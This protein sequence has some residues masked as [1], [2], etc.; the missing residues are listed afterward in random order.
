MAWTY[1]PLTGKQIIRL[2]VFNEIREKMNEVGYAVRYYYDF[3]YEYYNAHYTNLPPALLTDKYICTKALADEFESLYKME[4]PDEWNT[5]HVQWFFSSTFYSLTFAEFL[6]LVI[7]QPAFTA[8]KS[9]MDIGTLINELYL[10]LDYFANNV[11]CPNACAGTASGQYGWHEDFWETSWSAARMAATADA[12]EGFNSLQEVYYHEP[13]EADTP[14]GVWLTLGAA[15]NYLDEFGYYAPNVVAQETSEDGN[16][17]VWGWW[18][19]YLFNMV[20]WPDAHKHASCTYKMMF[21]NQATSSAGQIPTT[22]YLN[23]TSLGVIGSGHVPQG[24]V[25]ID[26]NQSLIDFTLPESPYDE[27]NIMTCDENITAFIPPDIPSASGNWSEGVNYIGGTTVYHEEQ[28]Y[29]CI[30]DHLSS[31]SNE[32][33]HAGSESYW[34]ITGN[35]GWERPEEGSISSYI[36]ATLYPQSLMVKPYISWT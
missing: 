7:G 11:W 30:Q 9:I 24:R 3:Y 16:Q 5:D 34:E 8:P 15:T 35:Y 26:I 1:L 2:E 32:P 18:T 29:N 27:K 33:G 17:A 36:W 12:Q 10:A 4:T 23:G 14:P 6:T 20:Y 31:Y 22:F 28:Y 13:F 19:G 25:V 21:G